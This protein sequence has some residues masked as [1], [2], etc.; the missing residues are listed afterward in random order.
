MQGLVILAE[1]SKS[2]GR[3]VLRSLEDDNTDDASQSSNASLIDDV[4]NGDKSVLPEMF[5]IDDSSS[6]QSSSNSDLYV[7]GLESSSDSEDEDKSVKMEDTYDYLVSA[8]IEDSI[9]VVEQY[10]HIWVTSNGTNIS[11]AFLSARNNLIELCRK[12]TPKIPDDQQLQVIEIAQDR[13]CC[14]Q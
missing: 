10:T 4:K 1:A 8:N 2:C 11:D 6:S 14:W 13:K 5:E 9:N 3:E 12:P 7:P